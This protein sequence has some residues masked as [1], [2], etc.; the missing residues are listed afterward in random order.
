MPRPIKCRSVQFIPE[1]D[2]FKPA[3]IP[4][5]G[6]REVVLTIEETEALRLKDIES[7]EQEECAS[8]MGISRPTFHRILGS[9]R[10]KVSDAII[11]GKAIRIEGGNYK[12]CHKAYVKGFGRKRCPILDYEADHISRVNERV[13]NTEHVNTFPRRGCG[14]GRRFMRGGK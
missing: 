9:A 8:R 11:N 3:G 10:G 4:L 6:L 13:E 14:K 1:Y 2:Y 12:L 5:A 7:L